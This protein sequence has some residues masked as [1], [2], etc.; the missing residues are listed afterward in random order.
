MAAS[1]K[2]VEDW[3]P[4]ARAGSS[5]ALGEALEACRF[6]LLGVAQR[7]LDPVLQAKGGAS[8]LV[9]QTFLEAQQDF[10][11]FRGDSEAELLAW[12]RRL[13]LN[14]LANFARRYRDTNKRALGREIALQ[15]LSASG[16]QGGLRAGDP[17]PSTAMAHGEQETALATALTKLPDDYRQ[18]LLLRYEGELSFEEIGT[19]MNRTANAAR[20]LWL[21][22][23]ERLQ[24]ELGTSP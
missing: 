24:I 5:E 7:E 9:Q 11:R 10:P 17:S 2:S 13:L 15:A 3:L 19:K 23:I 12:L 6:Y 4:Q 8:D 16:L 14:N 21:R 1:A 20:K 22:A 18:V